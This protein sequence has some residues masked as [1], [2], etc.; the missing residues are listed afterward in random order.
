MNKLKYSIELHSIILFYKSY[1]MQTIATLE[2]VHLNFL[3]T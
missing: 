2:Q 3:R 1:V